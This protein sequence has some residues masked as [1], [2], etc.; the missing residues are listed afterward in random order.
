M[1]PVVCISGG[2]DPLHCGHVD[3]ING[4][5]EYG[6][7]VVILNSDEWLIRKKGYCFMPFAERAEILKNIKSVFKV[8]GVDDYDGSVCQA[9]K[10]IRPK[11]FANGGDRTKLNVKQQKVGSA[12]AKLCQELGII[13]LFNIGGEK[14]ASSSKLVKNAAKKLV[15]E[16]G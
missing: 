6:R 16:Q 1:K 5:A 12:E 15:Y 10:S 11:Y 2:F 8:A 13:Q 14:S 9:L 3:Y 7:V 4:A